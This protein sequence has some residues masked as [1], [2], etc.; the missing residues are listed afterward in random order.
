MQEKFFPL[1]LQYGTKL[2]IIEEGDKM[3][4]IIHFLLVSILVSGLLVQAG[5][6]TFDQMHDSVKNC[7]PSGFTFDKGQSWDNRFMYKITYQGDESKG[8]LLIFNLAPRTEGFSEID[9]AGDTEEFKVDGRSALYKN[10]SKT[11]FSILSIILKNNSGKF[12][13]SHR[14]FGGKIMDKTAFMEMLSKIDLAKL[15]K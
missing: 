5:E 13:V 1:L 15:E 4:K 12:Q 10:G 11:G 2:V 3:G 6:L 7:I 14:L 8:E 9:L